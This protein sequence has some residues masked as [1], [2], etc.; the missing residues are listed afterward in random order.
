[1]T[2]QLLNQCALVCSN[3][4]NPQAVHWTAKIIKDPICISNCFL[5]SAI[6]VSLGLDTAKVLVKSGTRLA[7]FR[8]VSRIYFNGLLFA[9]QQRYNNAYRVPKYVLLLFTVVKPLLWGSVHKGF[10]SSVNMVV[11]QEY[12]LQLW[13]LASRRYLFLSR[14]LFVHISIC[15]L[16]LSVC[17]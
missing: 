9:L 3:F 5:T 17:L 14:M 10:P 1:V 11:N 4:T 16:C 6:L 12:L 8:D 2:T 15:V 13:I 7:Q